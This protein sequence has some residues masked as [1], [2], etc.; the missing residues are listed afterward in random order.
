MAYDDNLA[1][2]VRNSFKSKRV[3]FEEKK[4]MGG[5]CFLVDDKMCIGVHEAR[6]MARIDPEQY[7][8]GPEEKRSREDDVHR[9]GDQRF[10]LCTSSRH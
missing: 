1:D 10:C 3:N 2:R 4:M 7:D 8:A 5:L 9:Q 6:L